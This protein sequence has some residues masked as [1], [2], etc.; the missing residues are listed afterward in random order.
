MTENFSLL[1]NLDMMQAPM[2]LVK[3]CAEYFENQ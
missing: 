1:D 3:T 2:T